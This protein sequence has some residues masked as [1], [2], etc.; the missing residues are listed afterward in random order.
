[1][2]DALFTPYDIGSLHLPN[3]WV[4]APM[5]RKRSPA[6]IPT[7][8]TAEY[9]RRRAAGGIGLI[10]TEGTLVDHPLAAQD[11]D[12]PGIGTATFSAW[13]D[14][15]SAVHSEGA[16]VFVQLWHQG[17]VARPG[18]G[19]VAVTEDDQEVVTQADSQA[20]KDL[21]DAFVQG[22]VNAKEIGFDG[23][24]LH[25]AHGY[26]L[27]SFIRNGHLPFVTELVQEIRR[28]VGPHYPLAIRFSQW[29]VRTTFEDRQFDTPQELEKTL[30]PLQEA[31]IDIFHASTRRFW[32]PEFSGSDLNLAGWTR[33]LT[34]A[35][36]IT[37]GN[38]GLSTKELCGDG[39]E[40]ATELM[41]R[42]EQGE[43]DM[44]ALG[45]PLL[46]DAEWVT[47]IQAGQTDS[48]IDYTPEANEIYP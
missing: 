14:V 48:I 27:D 35:P 4:M 42:Y 1:M 31:G 12:I 34:G 38:I 2:L 41:R 26:L 17:P 21:F 33:K 9:Y 36:T 7:A 32:I 47:K 11:T 10:V 39:S 45:R 18:I 44:V 24:E 40:S 6:G 8:T 16:K 46:S 43:F 23:I 30:L 37:V 29:R 13:R 22:A 19:A 20:Q 5:T 3:R 15:L 28:Q 25:G